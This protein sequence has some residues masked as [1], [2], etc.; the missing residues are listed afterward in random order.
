[1][2]INLH[3]F[4]WAW[5]GLWLSLFP[6]VGTSD[7]AFWLDFGRQPHTT[8]LAMAAVATSTREREAPRAPYDLPSPPLQATCVVQRDDRPGPRSRKRPLAAFPSSSAK[9]EKCRTQAQQRRM[10][11]KGP[12]EARIMEPLYPRYCRGLV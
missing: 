8:S 6:G 7:G 1:M 5:R 12:G 4:E 10:T 9:L 11:Q 2:R 3:V